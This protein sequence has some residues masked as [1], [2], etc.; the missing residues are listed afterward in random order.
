ML[1]LN[2]Y[3]EY[4]TRPWSQYERAV[5]VRNYLGDTR[6]QVVRACGFGF[7]LKLLF[8][9][10]HETMITV[11]ACGVGSVR[12]YYLEDTRKQV[13]RARKF[14][15]RL[16]G[17]TRKQV[18]ACDCGSK[19]DTII[20]VIKQERD[21]S[22]SVRL[23]FGSKCGLYKETSTIVQIWIWFERRYKETSTSVWL[24]FE[25]RYKEI[26]TKPWLQ[27]CSKHLF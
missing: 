7:G 25:R 8:W 9:I 19:G 5:L 4:N 22:M 6:K 23:R 24:Q 15:F 3:F 27:Y 13:V 14:V 21:H 26:N 18:Q 16:K 11:R 2:Y 1:V 17:E 10:E 12:N 20:W